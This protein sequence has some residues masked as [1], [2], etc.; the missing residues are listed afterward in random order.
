MKGL[1]SLRV[2]R[3]DAVTTVRN[4]RGLCGHG[5]LRSSPGDPL[6]MGW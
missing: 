4:L 2:V 6:T 3:L 5:S 1:P